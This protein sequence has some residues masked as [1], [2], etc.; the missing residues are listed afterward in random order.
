[1]VS[2]QRWRKRHVPVSVTWTETRYIQS[3]LHNSRYPGI[4]RVIHFMSQVVYT[5]KLREMGLFVWYCDISIMI[6]GRFPGLPSTTRRIAIKGS[7]LWKDGKKDITREN[8]LLVVYP[9]N[10]AKPISALIHNVIDLQHLAIKRLA[11][12]LKY[13]YYIVP[14]NLLPYACKA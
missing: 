8:T 5:I 3:S 14:N 7:R 1:M 13:K 11:S 9:F 12:R 4:V 10:Q 6:K 2:W